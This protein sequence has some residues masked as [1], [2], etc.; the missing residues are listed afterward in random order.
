[1][2]RIQVTFVADDDMITDAIATLYALGKKPTEASVRRVLRE[3][4]ERGGLSAECESVDERNFVD[5]IVI[6][7]D[8]W[9]ATLLSPLRAQLCEKGWQS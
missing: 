9:T 3:W 7:D 2:M 5:D 8:H 6:E 4:Y 1:M